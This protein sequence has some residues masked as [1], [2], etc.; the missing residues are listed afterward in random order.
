MSKRNSRKQKGR[1]KATPRSRHG[2][3]LVLGL[4]L[5]LSLMGGILAQWRTARRALL[6]PAPAPSVPGSP[7]KE[8]IYAGGGRLIGTEE[9][10]QSSAS[11]PTGLLASASSSSQVS[12]T[13]TAPTGV[14]HHY[15]VERSQNGNNFTA[16][17]GNPATTSFNDTTATPGTAYLYQ[18]RAADAVGN[19]S[20]PSNI[21]LATTI[22]FSDDPLSAGATVVK[23]QHLTEL[24][25]AVNAVRALAGLTAA[26][27]TDA[28]PMSVL[29]KAAHV[30]ELRTSLDQALSSL[31]LSISPYT[32]PTL[33]SAT[34]KAV[35]FQELRQRVK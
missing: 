11:A 20:A 13:W 35:H 6:S 23:A 25:Q 32:D 4:I 21:D 18:V 28:S 17:A 14:V 12:L 3:L 29:I 7:S 34:I 31:G 15:Q 10:A 30:Q 22:I 16:L 5:M 19:L 1:V 33:S 8:Y 9:P 26:A 24:R 27:W 2:V